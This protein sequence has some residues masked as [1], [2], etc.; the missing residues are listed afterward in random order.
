MLPDQIQLN[1]DFSDPNKIDKICI[2]PIIKESDQLTSIVLMELRVKALSE[3]I[4]E[5]PLQPSPQNENE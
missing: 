5:Q 4:E 2:A 1:N 3:K